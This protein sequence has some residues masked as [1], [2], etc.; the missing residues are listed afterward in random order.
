M[1]QHMLHLVN[2]CHYLMHRPNRIKKPNAGDCVCPN[3]TGNVPVFGVTA[4]VSRQR[5]QQR[6]QELAGAGAPA[7]V[8][9]GAEDASEAFGLLRCSVHPTH[10]G[11]DST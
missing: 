5:R 11:M 4:G 3:A 1:L 8:D 2:N 10:Q 6:Q 9:R 7:G